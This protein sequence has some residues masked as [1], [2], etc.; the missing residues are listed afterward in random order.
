M[1]TNNS[2]LAVSNLKSFNQVIVA[3]KT[4]EYL[5]QVLGTKKAAF[6]NNLTALVANNAMLQR[7]DPSS[8]MFAGIK[9]TALDLPLDSNLGFAYVIP[10]EN[11]KAGKVEAQFQMGYRGFIQLAIRTGKFKTINV[12][13]IREGE[14][15]SF[16]L[17]TGDFKFSAVPEREKKEVVGYAAFFRL[18][19]GF[20]KTL[21]MTKGEVEAHAK[22]YSQTYS[23]KNDYVRGASKW[24][25]DFD[26]MAKKTVLKLLLGKFAP[27]SVEMLD[28][29]DAD[30]AV[31]RENGYNYVDNANSGMQ[32][33]VEVLE[34]ER[35]EEANKETIGFEEA[36]QEAQEQAP[37]APG[38]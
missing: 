34:Q 17:L 30:Q 27:L 10:Y 33:A 19:N 14:I 13:E 26:A 21:Y 2:Q 36:L 11:R 37:E 12:T 1:A 18:N 15:D 35:A 9:A 3:D 16:D 20:E 7:C 8:L 5:R 22:Q 38:W 6:V 28:A 29:R 24:S 4:Q 25:T 31:I 23:S 32:E